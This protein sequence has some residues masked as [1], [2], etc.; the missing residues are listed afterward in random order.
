MVSNNGIMAKKK[1]PKP[2]SYFFGKMSKD[3]A[4]AMLKDIEEMRKNTAIRDIDFDKLII[5]DKGKRHRK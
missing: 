4:D 5:N 2:L 1:K 3:D